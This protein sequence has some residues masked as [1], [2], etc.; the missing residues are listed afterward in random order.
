MGFLVWV[1]MLEG[2]AQV[3]QLRAAIASYEQVSC[4]T[5]GMT[6]LKLAALTL[7]TRHAEEN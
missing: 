6:L 7:T 4:H 2:I 1:A 5:H 3:K